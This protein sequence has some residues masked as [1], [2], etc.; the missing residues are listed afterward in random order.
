MIYL[1]LLETEE[2][3]ERF[4][5]IYE[6]NYQKM[7]YLA[8]KYLGEPSEAENAV[9]EAFLAL[10]ERFE[11]YSHLPGR[12]MTGLCVSIVK[13]KSIDA[14]RRRRHYSE[15]ELEELVLPDER[16]GADP[17]AAAEAGEEARLLWR[18]MKQIS[19]VF[20]E[21]LILKYC[22]GMGNREIAKLQGVPV[23]TVEMR[24]YRGK[25]KLKELLDEETERGR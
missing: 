14:L 6:E 19:E 23:K 12:E 7:Y 22:Y 24:L 9:H 13:N 17:V 21:T 5:S 20:R 15:E 3:R 10:A 25:R 18:A 16:A 4:R 11:K 1:A 2:D 8:K